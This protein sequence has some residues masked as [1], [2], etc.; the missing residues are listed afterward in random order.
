V[1]DRG[2]AAVP[3]NVE[4]IGDE[5][6]I[7]WEEGGETYLKLADLRRLCP[8]AGCAGERDLLG[9]LAKPPARPLT[10]ESFR[11]QRVSPV[12]GYAL[13]VFWGDGHSDGL[14]GYA[15]LREWGENPPQLPAVTAMPLLPSR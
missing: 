11:V 4:V 10:T 15:R 13:Q 1:Y 5:L 2:V 9:R 7:V 14:Y 8:C 3:K 12:G 6:A